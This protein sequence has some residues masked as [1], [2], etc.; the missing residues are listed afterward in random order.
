MKVL[1][2][3]DGSVH[4]STAILT[5]KRLLRRRGLSVDILCVAPELALEASVAGAARG[6]GRI[7][8]SYREHVTRPTS[9]ILESAHRLLEDAPFRVDTLAKFGSPADQLVALAPDYD[10]T[11]IGSYGKHERK[12]PGL[13]PI[14]SQVMQLADANVM[15]GRELV[16]E[17]GHR[18]LV[19]LDSSD[20]SFRALRTL[21]SFFDV[22][23]L[24]VT[25]MHVVELPWAHIGLENWAVSEEEVSELE[26][27]QVRLEHELRHDAQSVIDR[28]LHQLEQW[29]VPAST[30]IEEGDP[31]LELISH[32][33]EGG[34]DL[35]VAGATGASDVKHARIGSV[36]LKLAWNA[37][38]SVLIVRK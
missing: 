35:V 18:V 33:E 32:A 17:D 25:L 19:A 38:C 11:V 15:V 14:S 20:A 8:E 1:M 27:Y 24:D 16:N 3:T 36:S 23:S 28:G 12:Q 37:P 4:A 9:R 21:G 31:A 34:Y 5:A 2:A 30:I 22:S 29:R 6:R 13:G 26:D 10:L 7:Q